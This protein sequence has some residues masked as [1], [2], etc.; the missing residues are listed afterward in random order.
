M[1][2]TRLLI[3]FLLATIV[4]TAILSFMLPTSQKAE[5]SIV[6]NAPATI[7]YNQLIKLE[8]FNKFSVWS[9]QDS[10]AVYILT[11][12]DGTIGATSSWAGH[13]QISGKGKI[14]ILAL[15]PNSTVF[16][17]IHFINPK[18]GN[19]ESVFSLVETNKAMTT[20]T[21]TFRMATPRPRNIF[22]LLYSL[23]KEKG[24]D[25]EEGLKTLKKMIESAV[26]PVK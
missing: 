7:I 23:D 18:K 9:Q 26:I 19:A 4:T 12:T 14:E 10:S 25:F 24:K 15:V 8:F 11:G 6:I 21:W 3:F 5:R 13:P 2:F 16:H 1:R 17:K 22:N 20:V